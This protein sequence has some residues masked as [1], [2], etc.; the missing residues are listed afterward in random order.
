MKSYV[1]RRWD[2]GNV[3]RRRC[4]RLV[5][6]LL[7]FGAHCADAP[8][9]LALPYLPVNESI[10]LTYRAETET[11]NTKN[12]LSDGSFN[13]FP[14]GFLMGRNGADGIFLQYPLTT[15][16]KGCGDLFLSPVFKLANADITLGETVASTGTLTV[17]EDYCFKPPMSGTYS[18]TSRAVGFE[19]VATQL[20]TFYALRFDYSIRVA[21]NNGEIKSTAWSS[22]LVSG[23]GVVKHQM[24]LDAGA[25]TITELIA[26]NLTAEA[27]DAQPN[28][29]SFNRATKPLLNSEAVSNAAVISGIN[30]GVTANITGGGY[31]IN[32]GAFTSEPAI[33]NNGDT[34]RVRV[35]ASQNPGELVCATLN[36]GTV[37]SQF[38]GFPVLPIVTI[39]LEE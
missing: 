9:F 35:M 18:G 20:G 39:L 12:V 10:T 15:L 7:F 5:S 1:A 8:A 29:L 21:A 38:C 33:V 34:V 31:S 4:I 23:I 32:G 3:A 22:W 17:V 36:V 26:T 14:I 27:L 24:S 13:G 2:I 11:Y 30:V 6:M 19:T 37:V 28:P 25:P 16:T